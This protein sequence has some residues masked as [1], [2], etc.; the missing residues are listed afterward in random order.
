[1]DYRN[2]AAAILFNNGIPE[3][4]QA[5]SCVVN[6]LIAIDSFNESRAFFKY[7]RAESEK[8]DLINAHET[9]TSV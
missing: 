8:L 5:L 6:N 2:R 9:Q 1:M 3:T 4:E 7:M